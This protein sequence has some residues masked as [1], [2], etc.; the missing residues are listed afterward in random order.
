MLSGAQPGREKGNKK[1]PSGRADN[2][3][4]NEMTLDCFIIDH[5]LS[6]QTMIIHNQGSF[7]CYLGI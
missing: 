6:L 2:I 3:S 5:N 7:L 1:R 4:K